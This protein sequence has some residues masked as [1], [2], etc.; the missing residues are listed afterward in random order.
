MLWFIRML[1]LLLLWLLGM[2]DRLLNTAE[3]AEILHVPPAT[4]RWWRHK[5][6]GPKGFRLGRRLIMSKQSDIESWLDQQYNAEA[7]A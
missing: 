5:G 3:A 4:M 2:V 1:M 6:V 7:T